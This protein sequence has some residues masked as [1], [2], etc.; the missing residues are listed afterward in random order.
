[1]SITDVNLPTIDPVLLPCNPD[2]SDAKGNKQLFG[3]AVRTERHCVFF[4]GTARNSRSRVT[5]MPPKRMA[6]LTRMPR[7]G[8][9]TTT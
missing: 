5:D 7:L 4:H 6:Q 9:H 8:H 2:A 1:M 3:K